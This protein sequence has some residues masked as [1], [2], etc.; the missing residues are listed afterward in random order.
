MQLFSEKLFEEGG[1]KISDETLRMWLME[2]GQWKRTRKRGAYRQ[3]RERKY[4]FGEM[5]Q[6]D[7]RHHDWFEDREEKC[8]FMGYIADATGK[9]QILRVTRHNSCGG[10]F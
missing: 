5:V 1:L 10:Q 7:G 4:C 9:R 6:M 2:A 3:W 8:V